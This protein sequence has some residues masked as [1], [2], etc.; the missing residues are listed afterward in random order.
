MKGVIRMLATPTIDKLRILKL[1]GMSAAF[2]EQ[3]S[4]SDYAQLPFDDRLAL[5]VDRE[6]LDRDNRRLATRLKTAKLRSQACVEDIIY[7]PNRGLDK[8]LV[9]S[10]LSGVWIHDSRN[11]IITG[12]CG[13]GKTYL[14][15][16]LAHRACMNGYK[17]LYIRTP[18]LLEDLALAHGDGR[19]SRLISSFSKMNLLILD[20]WLLSHLTEPQ[21]KDLFEIIEDRHGRHATIIV[22]QVPSEH[23]HDAI[24]NP[25]IAD[26]IL[27]RIIHNAYTIPLQGES[28]R[29]KR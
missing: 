26:A 20:D 16:A 10:L 1:T 21:S 9:Q 22:S 4:S 5:L 7:A 12:P 13:V 19:Y 23:W 27:D 2:A 11:I 24:A 3:I 28:L 8:S 17:S 14:A 15:C 6:L 29:K 25:T 18:R